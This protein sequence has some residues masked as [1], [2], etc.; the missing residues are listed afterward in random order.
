MLKLIKSFVFKI[1][2]FYLEDFI[3][4]FKMNIILY[5]TLIGLVFTAPIEKDAIE[6]DVTG[7]RLARPWMGNFF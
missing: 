2:I 5:L 6:T 4:I 7:A 1:I 3:L